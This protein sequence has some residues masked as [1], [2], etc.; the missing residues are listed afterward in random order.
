MFDKTILEMDNF[1]NISLSAKAIYFLLGM[2]ADDEGFVSPNRIIRLYGGEIG[3]LKNLVDAG[4]IIPFQSGVVVITD[5]NQNNW[6]DKRRIKPTQYQKEKKLI[7][8][9]EDRKYVLSNGLASARLE[10]ER[11]GEER[12]VHTPTKVG[13][14]VPNETIIDDFNDLT[15]EPVDEQIYP[16]EFESFWKHYPKKVGKGGAYR[17]WKKIKP[18]PNSKNGLLEKILHKL[19]IQGQSVQWKRDNGQFIPHPQTYLNQRRW[20]D[21]ESETI[22]NQV[23]KF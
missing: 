14:C 6:L 12:R 10:E 2:E 16:N 11:R 1:L 18:S 3:D 22:N 13:E 20:E 15:Y 8:L 21:E 9:T 23:Q 17:S 4:L 5:W 19:G 7:K